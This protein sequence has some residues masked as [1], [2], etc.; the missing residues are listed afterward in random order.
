METSLSIAEKMYLFSVHP[1]KGGIVSAAYS[2]L[3]PVLTGAILFDLIA[4]KK[5]ILEEKRIIL[6]DNKGVDPLHD[7]LLEKI[8]AASKPRTAMNWIQRFS[9]S[10]KKIKSYVKESLKQKRLIRIEQ[11]QFLF[12][13]WDKVFLTDRVKVTG[14]IS[15]IEAQIKGGGKTPVDDGL[16]SLLIPSE[17]LKRMF[18]DREKRKNIKSRLKQMQL[19]NVVSKA[20]TDVIRMSRAAA[21]S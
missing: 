3:V 19:E 13:R 2:T 8:A 5:L 7:F 11:R 20:V 6:N 9:W 17:L 10:S 12:F 21:V 18:P 16:L 4:S 14:F 15:E 1:E